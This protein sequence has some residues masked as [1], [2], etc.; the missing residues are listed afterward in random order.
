MKLIQ[1]LNSI[2]NNSVYC[3]LMLVL[4]YVEKVTKSQNYYNLIRQTF[5]RTVEK[6]FEF[7]GLKG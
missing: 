4:L 7:K 1:N 5:M 3:M 6:I 2:F